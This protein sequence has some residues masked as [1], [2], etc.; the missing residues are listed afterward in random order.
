MVKNASEFVWQIIYSI[1]RE[2]YEDINDHRIYIST[3]YFVHVIYST[4]RSIVGV[5]L[6]S[7][8]TRKEHIIINSDIRPVADNEFSQNSC[9]KKAMFHKV[10]K[11]TWW[12]FRWYHISLNSTLYGTNFN[13]KQFRKWSSEWRLAQSYDYSEMY[14]LGT[15]AG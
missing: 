3:Q 5:I 13:T 2:R 15:V 10:T 7:N 11:I 9:Y 1:C 12:H 6:M 8:T 4:S 14:D